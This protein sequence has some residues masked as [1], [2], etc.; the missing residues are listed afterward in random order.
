MFVLPIDTSSRLIPTITK[1]IH[2]LSIILIIFLHHFFIVFCVDPVSKFH[3]LLTDII[4]IRNPHKEPGQETAPT[5]GCDNKATFVNIIL[6][7]EYYDGGT[8]VCL[9]N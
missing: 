5:R 4:Q 1:G 9:A 3:I 8:Y 2:D 7:G 6:D